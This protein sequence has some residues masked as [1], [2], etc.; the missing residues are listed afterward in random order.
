MVDISQY[1][2]HGAV[3][4]FK[5]YINN[6]L[7]ILLSDCYKDTMFSCR[8]GFSRETIAHKCAP[9]EITGGASDGYG[10]NQQL[11]LRAFNPNK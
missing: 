9:T 6:N 1:P 4:D 11:F 7:R 8:S 10:K 5:K 3:I 2:L